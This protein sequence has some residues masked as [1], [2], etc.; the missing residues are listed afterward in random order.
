MPA[1]PVQPRPIASAMS[2]TP[3]TQTTAVPTMPGVPNITP[4]ST[5]ATP[6]VA[7]CAAQKIRSYSCST[8]AHDTGDMT[9]LLPT[10]GDP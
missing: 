3:K 6:S 7:P 10:V 2:V 5:P 9:E 8:Q 4:A 1:Q